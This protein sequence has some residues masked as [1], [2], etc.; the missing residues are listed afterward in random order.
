MQLKDACSL[1][2]KAMTN[3]DSILKIRAVTLLT[4]V[5]LLKAMVFP[6]VMCWC[7]SWTIKKAE[8]QR[9][10]AFQIVVLKKTLE[11]PLDYK[12]IKPVN[13]KENQPQIFIRKAD[14]ESEAPMFWPLD[15]KSWLI[16]KHPG[17][18]KNGRQEEKGAAEDEMV[19]WHH[20]LNGLE[21]EQTPGDGEAQGSLACCRL[22]DHKESDAT[23]WLYNNNIHGRR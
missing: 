12:E 8:H 1:G 17:A 15:V 16:G 10:D 13:H 2:E 23:E 22:W 18:R 6:V 11:S 20:W 7:E 9:I 19:G 3:L 5:P 21:F 14:A 4:K